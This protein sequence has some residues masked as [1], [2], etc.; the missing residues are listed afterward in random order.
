MKAEMDSLN[1]MIKLL[2]CL[3]GYIQFKYLDILDT[4]ISLGSVKI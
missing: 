3:I 4:H 2:N 1:A